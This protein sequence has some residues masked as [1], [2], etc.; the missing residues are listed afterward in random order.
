MENP[1]NGVD[2]AI[3]SQAPEQ[4]P[5]QSESPEIDYKAELEKAQEKLKKAEYTLYKKNVEAKAKEVEA[6]PEV[7]IDSRVEESVNKRL[8]QITQDFTADAID[9]ALDAVSGS[10]EERS[11]VRFHYDNSIQ[12]TGVSKT[13]I[14][15]D[16]QKAKLLANAPKYLKENKEMQES[17]KSKRTTSMSSMGANVDTSMQ[18]P[19]NDDLQKKFSQRD[20]DFMKSRGWSED[21][22]RQAANGQNAFGERAVLTPKL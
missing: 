5:A 22:I 18:I 19:K 17:L 14:F 7:D 8:S 16:M 12:R 4:A 13:Q 10:A 6:A 11:L 2:Q 20:W 9:S 15:E 3:D 21:R 1:T